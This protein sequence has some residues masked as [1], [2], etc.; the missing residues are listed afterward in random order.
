IADVVL[1]GEHV[2]CGRAARLMSMR[3]LLVGC[4]LGACALASYLVFKRAGRGPNGAAELWV[5]RSPVRGDRSPQSDNVRQLR[6]CHDQLHKRKYVRMCPLRR[7]SSLI[8]SGSSMRL[9]RCSVSC[10]HSAGT[11]T[12]AVPWERLAGL[13]PAVLNERN[14]AK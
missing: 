7:L 1:D 8:A 6:R 5:P 9:T 11:A 2:V 4:A 10:T 14:R 12:R 3:R 13:A